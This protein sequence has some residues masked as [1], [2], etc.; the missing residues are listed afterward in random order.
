MKKVLLQLIV[1]T[2]IPCMGQVIDQAHLKCSY[3]YKYEFDTLSHKDVRD[4]LLYLQIGKSISKCF[5]YYTYQNDSL[6][7]SPDGEKKVSSLMMEAFTKKGSR[8][9]AFPHKRMTAC[10]YK[11]YPIGKVTITDHLMDQY[12]VYEDDLYPQTWSMEDSTKLVMGHECQKAVCNFRGR[13]WTA[14]FAVDIPI[15]DGPWIFGGLPGLIMDVYDRKNQHHFRINGL[16]KVNNEPIEFIVLD[17]NFKK[18]VQTDRIKFLRSKMNYY[19]NNKSINEA[20][21][22][23][24]LNMPEQ[25]LKR[26]L[27]ERDYK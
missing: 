7:N 10:I 27:L 21:T 8:T 5:S 16:Q 14:W 11:N 2:F 12:Y 15:S 6:W 9:N 25:K 4:D 13:E 19:M 18:L 23:I 24:S 3:E 20:M 17:K 1:F 26:D 22:G